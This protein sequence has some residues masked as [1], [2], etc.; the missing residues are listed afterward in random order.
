MLEFGRKIRVALA[1]TGES[2]KEL[3]EFVGVSATTVSDSWIKKSMRPMR[4]NALSICDFFKGEIT[5]QDLGH[6]EQDNDR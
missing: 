6:E 5:M 2:Q 3:A 1:Q 4:K